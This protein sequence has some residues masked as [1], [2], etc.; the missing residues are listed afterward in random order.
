VI[1]RKLTS[2]TALAV[3][4]ILMTTSISWAGSTGRRNTALAATAVAVGAWSNGTGR[5]GR[6]NTAILTT[7][8][9]AYA[10]SQYANKKKQE[11]RRSR[12]ARVAACP[13]PHE[14]LSHRRG[15]RCEPP[16]RHLGWYKHGE[17]H[18]HHHGRHD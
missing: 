18:G 13:P 16:G 12:Y 15:E 6:R 7:A 10:W 3:A 14:W 17:Y 5:A 9:A 1:V 11:K 2:G 8:G 4:G